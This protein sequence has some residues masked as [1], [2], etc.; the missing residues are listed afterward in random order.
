M[1]IFRFSLFCKL[2]RLLTL[3][4]GSRA[5]H[6]VT[7]SG[8]KESIRTHAIHMRLSESIVSR[9][10]GLAELCEVLKRE[11]LPPNEVR[12]RC[13]WTHP[14]RSFNQNR[15]SPSFSF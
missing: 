12:C 15:H 13:H 11:G 7:A 10:G 5:R 3:P 9:F 14:I 6:K 2:P 1:L 4:N 8:K